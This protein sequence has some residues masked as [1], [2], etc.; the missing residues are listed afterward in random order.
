MEIEIE[1]ANR[2]GDVI[3][4][5]MTILQQN[6]Q[7]FTF[8]LNCCNYLKPYFCEEVRRNLAKLLAVENLLIILALLP[9]L[10]LFLGLGGL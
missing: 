10:F 2:A 8:I 3:Q 7:F 1:D 4:R 6:L 5:V 9:F